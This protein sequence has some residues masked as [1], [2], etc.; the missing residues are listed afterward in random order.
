MVGRVVGRYQEKKEQQLR[1]EVQ[2]NCSWS[3]TCVTTISCLGD[4]PKLQTWRGTWRCEDSQMHA[5]DTTLRQMLDAHSVRWVA[6]V[7]VCQVGK[8]TAPHWTHNS[9]VQEKSLQCEAWAP[10]TD[11]H[12]KIFCTPEPFKAQSLSRFFYTVHSRLTSWLVSWYCN[13]HDITRRIKHTPWRVTH[14]NTNM[15]MHKSAPKHTR[16]RLLRCP[17]TLL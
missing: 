12:T 13:F 8:S 15:C 3:P 16:A 6:S 5:A 1:P 4:I 14:P 7:E 9:A 17:A 10:W 2:A 11:L